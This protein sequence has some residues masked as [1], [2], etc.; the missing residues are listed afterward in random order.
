MLTVSCRANFISIA[1]KNPQRCYLRP[2][3]VEEAQKALGEDVG[4]GHERQNGIFKASNL[5]FNMQCLRQVGRRVRDQ[6][7][8]PQAAIEISTYLIAD[9]APSV[10]TLHVNAEQGRTATS[11]NVM[12]PGAHARARSRAGV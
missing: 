6:V 5:G 3:N 8:D 4:P 1:S 7:A 2:R 9:A 12:A 11:V 10:G